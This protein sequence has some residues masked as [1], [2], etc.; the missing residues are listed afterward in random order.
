[1]KIGIDLRSLQDREYAGIGRYVYQICKQL[2][3]IDKDNDYFFYFNK[4]KKIDYPKFTK[5]GT[6]IH[7]KVPTKFFNLL[8]RCCKVAFWGKK[9]KLDIFWQPSVN[10]I[11]LPKGIKK[12]VTVHDISWLINKRW[13]SIKMLL[14]HYMQ[15]IPKMVKTADKIIAVSNS[16]KSDVEYFFHIPDK[17]IRV[18]YSGVNRKH[19][20]YNDE[21]RCPDK[22]LLF[23]GAIEPRKNING[24]VQALENIYS[25]Y[26][27]YGDCHLVIIG[28]KGWANGKL[29]KAIKNSKYSDKFHYI[30]YTSDEKRDYYIRESMG[31][32]WP[33]FYEGFG[34]P[35]L[36]AILSNKPVVT[37]F[38]SSLPEIVQ[39]NAILVDPYNI[40]DIENAIIEI[41]ENPDICKENTLNHDEYDW[42]KT[43]R[44][45]IEEFNKLI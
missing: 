24:I 16:T 42:A 23:V 28:A 32:I 41:L 21:E 43:A 27:Q 35:P 19:Y 6:I 33:S 18:I 31:I 3:A 10:F 12:I 1:M 4:S 7:T 20:E 8:T 11:H 5:S 2:V 22:Y 36:E 17:Q 37:S 44:A 25:K 40:S 13:Y 9:E 29:H 39:N 38:G 34:H 45:Y 14:W 15:N 30:G 26:P